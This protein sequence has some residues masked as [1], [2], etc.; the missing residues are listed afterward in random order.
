MSKPL[1]SIAARLAAEHL[2]ELI[3]ALP[4]AGSSSAAIREQEAICRC[5]PADE[6]IAIAQ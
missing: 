2:V 6:K 4:R 3:E 5:R 1:A